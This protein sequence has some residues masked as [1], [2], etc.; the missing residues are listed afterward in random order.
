MAPFTV[1]ISDNGLAEIDGDPLVPAPEQSVHEAVL[2]QLHRF[3]QQRG[4]AVDATVHD[5][6]G[7]AEFFLRVLPD[8]SSQVLG[9]AEPV[10]EPEPELVA[11]PEPEPTP[12]PLSAPEPEP[13]HA[14]ADADTDAGAG[15]GGG[16]VAKA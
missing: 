2:D 1:Y 14:R 7:A 4:T 9:A 15:P 16:A 6:P 12:E 8:G 3:A 10:Q 13:A 11:A 5:S